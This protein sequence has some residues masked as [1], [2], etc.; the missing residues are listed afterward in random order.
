M[1]LERRPG[2]RTSVEVILDIFSGRRNPSWALTK[3][4][5]DELRLRLKRLPSSA[6]R[7]PPQLGYRG[8]IITNNLKTPGIPERIMA[9]DGVLALTNKGFIEYRADSNHVEKW[10][11]DKARTG[12]FRKI[13][14]GFIPL[15]ARRC[16]AGKSRK[17]SP[18]V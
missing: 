5:L 8:V 6:R 1:K 10:I 11:L 3:P 15:V 4:E 2:N 14:D 17:R 9:Y 7:E 18:K 13:V 12:R 16:T